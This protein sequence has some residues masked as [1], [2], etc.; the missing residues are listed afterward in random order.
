MSVI[1]RSQWRRAAST[2]L[3]GSSVVSTP[4]SEIASPFDSIVEDQEVDEVKEIV[5]DV[6]ARHGGVSRQLFIIYSNI[7]SSHRV[8]ICCGLSK[9]S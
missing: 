3:L 7:D 4:A 5:K 8:E 2:S 6:K 1:A 9:D